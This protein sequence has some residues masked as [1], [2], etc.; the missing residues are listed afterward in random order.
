MTKRKS[1]SADDTAKEQPD[2]TPIAY[3]VKG[4]DAQEIE[5]EFARTVPDWKDWSDEQLAK[6]VALM[7]DFW[8]HP[9]A[10]VLTVARSETGAISLIPKG[11]ATVHVLRNAETFASNSQDYVNDRLG[12]ISNYHEAANKRG[13]T[14]TNVNAALSFIREGKPQDTVQS[15][16][17]TQMS[18]THDAA[19]RALSMIG[20]ADFTDH[21]SAFGNLSTK[22]LNA[23]ARQA[24]TLHKLQRGAEQTVR[25]VY[26]DARTQTAINCPP[27]E[28]ETRTQAHEQ[29][30][31]GAFG[32]EMLGYDKAWNGVPATSDQREKALQPSRRKVDGSKGE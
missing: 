1:K 14:D 25:H 30:E 20:K 10:P 9:V 18:A 2:E 16:L 4:K 13:A 11:N 28:T 29:H 26:V 22:L 21:M 8:Q 23:Y 27:S 19:M 12:D 5:A 6:A 31:G 24:E 32:P 15:T 7:L 17:L 3:L